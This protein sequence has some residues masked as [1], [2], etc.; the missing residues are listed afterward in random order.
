MM[1]LKCVWLPLGSRSCSC[2]RQHRIRLKMHCHTGRRN[3]GLTWFCQQKA[4]DSSSRTPLGQPFLQ[5]HQAD[6]TGSGKCIASSNRIPAQGH[7]QQQPL[8]Q[9]STGSKATCIATSKRSPAKEIPST[10]TAGHP[11]QLLLQLQQADLALATPQHSTAQHKELFYIR[12]LTITTAA[13]T[14]HSSKLWRRAIQ[15]HQTHGSSRDK[16]S[17]AAQAETAECIMSGCM[18]GHSPA[19][20]SCNQITHYARPCKQTHPRPCVPG[21]LKLRCNS[22]MQCIIATMQPAQHSDAAADQACLLDDWVHCNSCGP[23]TRP[24]GDVSLSP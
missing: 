2:S 3:P 8:L 6:S 21:C 4:F 7:H 13:I 10:V 19:L 22:V 1:D 15:Q 12:M 16:P 9:H 5:M 20:Y 17:M 18:Q 24:K 14:L 23:D 11:S